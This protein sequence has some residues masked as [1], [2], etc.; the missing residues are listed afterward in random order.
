MKSVI[1]YAYP[2]E[3]DGLSLQGD[4]LYRGMK[5]NGEAVMPC[6]VS[7]E[8]QKDWIYKHFKPDVAIGV[9]FWGY[10]PNIILNPQKFGVTPVPWL[11]ADGW[12]ANYHD[13]LNSLPLVFTTSKWV[14]DVYARDGVNVKNFKV[15]PVGVEPEIFRP[16]P[17]TDPAIRKLRQMLGV[18]SGEKMI[19]TVGGDVTS[20][21]AQEILK[22]LGKINKEFGNWKYICKSWEGGSNRDYHSEELELIKFLGLDNSRVSF[23][24]GAYSREFMPYLLNAA[25]VYA[26]PSR[27][28]GFGMIQLEAQACGIPVISIDAMGPKDTV[29]HGETGYLAK[30]ESTIDLDSELAHPDMGFEKEMRIFFNKSKTFAYRASVDD[31]ASYLLTLLTDDRKRI[32]MGSAAREHAVKNFNYRDLAA[33]MTSIIKERL[34]LK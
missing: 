15:A 1:L 31:L 23:L 11:V 13:V 29:I 25:D 22:A 9:G 24:G 2:P 20:K 14:V 32:A 21:G 16:I 17:K 6:H 34:S 12:V 30:V 27:I 5:E 28:E 3:S 19:L 7:G 10:T 4:M 26:A 33:K 8:L 18:K